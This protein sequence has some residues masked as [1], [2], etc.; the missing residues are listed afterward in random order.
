MSHIK[1]EILFVGFEA[2]EENNAAH[3][4]KNLY[5]AS[6]H[7]SYCQTQSDIEE[8][9]VHEIVFSNRLPAMIIFNGNAP[10]ANELMNE[11]FKQYPDLPMMLIGLVVPES[12][13]KMSRK[14]KGMLLH[15]PN[16]W[17]GQ[18][19]MCQIAHALNPKQYQTKIA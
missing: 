2:A 16:D 4:F 19:K 10:E 14:S 6:F 3:Q 17:D 12:F 7:Y 1:R 11:F 13:T 15:L 5:Q 9:I 18:D 8:K